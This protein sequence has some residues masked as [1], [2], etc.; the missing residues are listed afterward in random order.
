MH[1]YAKF[2]ENR[3]TFAIRLAVRDTNYFYCP[4]LKHMKK[5]S[6]VDPR[7]KYTGHVTVYH[8]FGTSDK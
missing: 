3:T 4:I 6:S 2:Y 8:V 5:F 1:L 7:A